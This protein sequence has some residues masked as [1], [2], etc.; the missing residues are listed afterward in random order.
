[1]RKLAIGIAGAAVLLLAGALAWNA[2]ATTLTSAT[3][4]YPAT[5]FSLAEKAGCW[6]PGLP[7]ECELGQQKVCDRFHKRGC[8]CVPCPGWYPW[9]QNTPAH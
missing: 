1:M 3:T 9:R 4:A 8:H 2:E 6:L 7:G 5:S